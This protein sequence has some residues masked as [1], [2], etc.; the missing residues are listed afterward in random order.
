MQLKIVK[1]TKF[2]FYVFYHEK[3]IISKKLL[4]I[5]ASPQPKSN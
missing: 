2:M 5:L 1:M 4:S 3:K